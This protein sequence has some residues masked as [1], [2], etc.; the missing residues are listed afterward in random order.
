MPKNMLADLK[1][2]TKHGRSLNIQ[3]KYGATAVS[4]G[5]IYYVYYSLLNIHLPR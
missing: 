2:S 5:L 1:D 3:D 4:Q